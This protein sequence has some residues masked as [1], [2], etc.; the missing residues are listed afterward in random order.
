MIN[1]LNESSLHKTL[2]Q[3]YSADEGLKTEVNVGKWICDIVNEKSGQVIEIQNTNVSKLKEKIEGLL[4]LG[5]K[6]KVVHPVIIE[7]TIETYD[8]NGKLLSKRKSPK[9]ESIYSIFRQITALT[10]ILLNKNFTLEIPEIS[11]IELRIITESPVQVK[12]KARHHLKSWLKTDKKLSQ[13]YNTW[14]FTCAKDY[15]NLLPQYNLKDKE[16]QNDFTV[17]QTQTLLKN[18]QNLKNETSIMIWVLKK[19]DI[20]EETYKEK[21]EIHYKINI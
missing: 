14:T 19:M 12:N 15:L 9:K 20:I 6:V 8:G 3:I 21:R 11:A 13:I 5:K 10:D 7:K 4:S 16:L 2:K 17:K 18:L 1:T